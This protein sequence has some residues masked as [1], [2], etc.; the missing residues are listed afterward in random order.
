VNALTNEDWSLK[1]EPYRWEI[2][3]ETEVKP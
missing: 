2:K 3:P 1:S